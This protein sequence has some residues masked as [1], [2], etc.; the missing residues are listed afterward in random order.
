MICYHLPHQ[1]FFLPVCWGRNHYMSKHESLGQGARP[2]HRAFVN[3]VFREDFFGRILNNHGFLAPVAVFSKQTANHAVDKEPRRTPPVK[4]ETPSQPD[5]SPTA[6][7]DSALD[8]MTE[9]SPR[10]V[11]G[12]IE[13]IGHTLTARGIS[14]TDTR[15][16]CAYCHLPFRWK[17]IWRSWN[18]NCLL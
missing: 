4:K 1:I 7:V 3:L 13:H 16:F 17:E 2:E 11:T 6:F 10:A 12:I 14:G 5:R 9:D 15:N 8:K 18:P